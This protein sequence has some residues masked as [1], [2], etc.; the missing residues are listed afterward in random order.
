M[1][2]NNTKKQRVY[3]I[4]KKKINRKRFVW[5]NIDSNLILCVYN[6]N[7]KIVRK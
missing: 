4:N 3:V 6:A 2:T 5:K 7:E 1:N